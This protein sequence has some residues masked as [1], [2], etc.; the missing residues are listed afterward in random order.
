[1]AGMRDHSH[2]STLHTREH[3]F[4]KSHGQQDPQLQLT[5]SNSMGMCYT[6]VPGHRE[7]D[8]I[9]VMLEELGHRLG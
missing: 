8:F 4:P 1:M 2:T 5:G 6:R 3:A 7:R 9:M